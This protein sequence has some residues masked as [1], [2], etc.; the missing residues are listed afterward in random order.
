MVE[1][2][3]FHAN[4]KYQYCVSQSG[5]HDCRVDNKKNGDNMSTQV[6]LILWMNIDHKENG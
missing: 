5:E 6:C 4:P 2:K 1:R 3:A